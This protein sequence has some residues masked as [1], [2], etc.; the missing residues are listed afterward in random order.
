MSDNPYQPGDL[1]HW[2]VGFV[3]RMGIVSDA[4]GERREALRC[5]DNARQECGNCDK[6]MKS[7]QCPRER[8][9]SGRQRGPSMSAPTCNQY[10]EKTSVQEWR[11]RAAQHNARALEILKGLGEKPEGRT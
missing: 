10:V 6:W 2:F 7:R 3:E 9:V 4:N 5:I 1:R 11:D 8:N